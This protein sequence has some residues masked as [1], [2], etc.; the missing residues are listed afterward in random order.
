MDHGTRTL[1]SDGPSCVTVQCPRNATSMDF[2]VGISGYMEDRTQGPAVVLSSPYDTLLR[3]Q[4]FPE[5]NAL[6]N[7]NIKLTEGGY[8][9]PKSVLCYESSLW[10]A[11][12]VV[13]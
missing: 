9:R 7:W 13:I 2:A 1:E 8:F 12:T 6:E 10:S 5:F 4:F 11:D 3:N